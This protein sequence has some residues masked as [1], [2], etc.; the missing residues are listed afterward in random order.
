MAT[1]ERPAGWWKPG[2]LKPILPVSAHVEEISF[3]TAI[4][5]IS[6]REGQ[7]VA[8]RPY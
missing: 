2:S 3:R 8:A 5:R 4:D 1:P 7:G 6:G